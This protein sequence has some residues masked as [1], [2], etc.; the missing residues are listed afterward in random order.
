MCGRF[1]LKTPPAQWNDF[2]CPELLKSAYLDDWQPRYNIAPTQRILVLRRSNNTPGSSSSNPVVW[3]RMRWG[4]LPAWADDVAI[5]NRMTNARSETLLEKRSFKGPLE[6]RRCV[7]MADGYYE[8][9]R[10]S[11][12]KKPIW[13]NSSQADLLYLA[14]LWETNSRATGREIHSCTIITTAAAEDIVD[15]HDRMPAILNQEAA[16]TWLDNDCDAAHAQQ[17]LEP[18]PNGWLQRKEAD[19]MVNNPRNDR[20][21]CL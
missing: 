2:L 12:G 14:G 16:L 6:K 18:T 17:L 11:K 13:F 9:Q 20:P 4:L 5:G 15:V 8:W 7:I 19:P 10:T 21:E 1:T 3:D